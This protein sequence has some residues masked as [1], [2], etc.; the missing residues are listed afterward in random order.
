MQL[1]VIADI[2]LGKEAVIALKERLKGK[3]ISAVIVAGD[4]TTHGSEFAAEEILKELKQI[5]RVFAVPGNLDTKEVLALLEN[6]GVSIHN[7]VVAFGGYKIT[8]FGGA[9]KGSAGTTNFSEKE[10][11]KSLEKLLEGD[12]G[13]TILVTHLP[14]FGTS[15]DSAQEGKHIG[16]KSVKK[17]IETKQPLLHICAHAHDS[18]GE[19]L[20]GKTISLNT[21][22]LE[23]GKA[24]IVDLDGK[25]KIERIEL[26]G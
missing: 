2:H 25:I 18:A 23:D 22:A 10:I 12:N 19:E 8:G 1:A 21:G 20:F 4:L 14:P 6:K 5:A 13:K 16:S 17:I 7:R 9:L 24:A 15:L 3:P 26:F 11:E